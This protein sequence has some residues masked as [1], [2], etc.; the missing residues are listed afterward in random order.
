M[1]TVYSESLLKTIAQIAPG[2]ELREGLERILRGRTGALIVLGSDKT[3]GQISSGGFV[4][5]TEFSATRVRELAKM[6][7]AIVCDKDASTLLAAGVQL[8]PDPSI[9]TNE[10]GT[11]HRTAERVAQQTG[12]PVIAVSASMS[13]ISVYTEG[14][15][16]T[17]EDTQSLM[18]R[19]NQAI[20]TLDSYTER[21]EQVLH[22]LSYLELEAGV[23]LRD[24]AS[25]LQRMEMVRRI[26]VEAGHYVVELGSVGR[27][28]ALQ[29]EELTTRNLPATWLVLRD[30]L[31]ID[32]M[33]E[34]LQAAVDALTQLDDKEIVDPLTIARTVGL[35]EE[36]DAPLH[37]HGHRLLAGIKSMPGAVA[38]RLV[39]RFDGLQSLMAASLD[40]LRAVEG[41]GEQRARVIRESLSRMAES[42]LLGR[43]M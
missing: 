21:L 37:P 2:T 12:F 26:T 18:S 42:S 11:R 20:R 10:S 22:Q 23:T 13:L 27:L 34:E 41:I 3:V 39:D 17:V 29:L 31:P 35:G 36:L 32:T 16:Y 19:A 43:F 38:D 40:D 9:E 1:L 7:G 30:Y 8:L 28:V 6:D 14:I 24:V 5:N 33:P 4:I 25:T 15:R